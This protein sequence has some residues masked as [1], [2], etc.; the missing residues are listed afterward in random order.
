MSLDR[1]I[2]LSARQ[3]RGRAGNRLRADLVELSFNQ[4]GQACCDNSL[5]KVA[6]SWCRIIVSFWRMHF[7]LDKHPFRPKLGSNPRNL[8]QATGVP[9]MR[10]HRASEIKSNLHRKH[11]ELNASNDES[12]RRQNPPPLVA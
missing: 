8:T 2:E 11:N 5:D 1:Q 9:I 10:Q 4:G 3:N 7:V 6:P 12:S